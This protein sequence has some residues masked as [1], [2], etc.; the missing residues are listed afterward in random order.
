MAQDKKVLTEQDAQWGIEKSI[1]A[2]PGSS[3][4]NLLGSLAL[5]VLSSA[6]ALAATECLIR[7]MDLAPSARLA[8]SAPVE[9]G[10]EPPA[11]STR[12][13]SRWI[14]HPFRGITPRTLQAI[15][16]G[17]SEPYGTNVFGIRSAVEDPRELLEEDLVI[18]IFGGSVARQIGNPAG[19]DELRE[20]VE[21]LLGPDAPKVRVVNFAVSGYKQPQQLHL[22]LELFILGVPI[23]VVVNIDGFNEVALAS[24]NSSRG[25]HPLYPPFDFWRSTLAASTASWSESQMELIVHLRQLRRRAEEYHSF[26]YSS[27][28]GRIELAKI[29]FGLRVLSLEKAA[30]VAELELREL[31]SR[32]PEEDI[33]G[34]DAPCLG[35][36]GDC[37]E[38][39]LDIW[40]NSS[41][42]MHAI[43]ENFGGTYLHFMQPSQYVDGK[44]E[45]T[46]EE[47]SRAW[48]PGREWSQAAMRGYPL[49][50]QRGK[51]LAEEEIDFHNMTEVFAGIT[52]PIYKDTCCHLTRR[53]AA[54]LGAA[55]GERVAKSQRRE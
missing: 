43:T 11:D 16:Q 32:N 7:I 39:I 12:P 47:R 10:H 14:V 27:W 31:P 17:S 55:I 49:L 4:R 26:I 19:N 28:L 40:A 42:S 29:A 8:A 44:R 25:H 54:I 3:P 34:L 33:Y 35:P 18:G 2:M 38:L 21:N 9:I 13:V 5:L 46:A 6:I 15:E 37:W 20:R 36:G 48:D 30:I 50:E 52:E 22:L 45:L 53:G 41:R 23:D 51:E 1:T 24:V